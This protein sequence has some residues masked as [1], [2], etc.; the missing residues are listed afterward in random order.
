MVVLTGA[1]ISAESGV[2]TFRGETG[3]W[4][5]FRP[6]DLATPEAFADQPVVVWEW[7]LH[8]RNLIAQVLP[9]PGHH[10]LVELERM[11]G[12]SFTLV[13]QNVDGLHRRAGS[14]NPIELHGNIF[15][16]RCGRC[17]DHWADDALDFSKLPPHC[18]TCAGEVRPGVVWFGE[19]LPAAAI[20]QAYSKSQ[21]ATLFISIGTSTVVHPAAGLPL[22]AMESGA[23]LIEINPEETPI[24]RL[25]DCVIREKSAT[26][27]PLLVKKLQ[28]L[29]NG[30]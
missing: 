26:T 20:D 28:S 25:S 9:N 5:Q 13:T 18:P 8:R 1:G 23:Y 17:Q 2:P 29:K 24:S 14:Q 3:L 30:N 27:L 16:N 15:V 10:A 11:L 6:E 22:L 19:S 21:R 7:Y 12:D 4:R